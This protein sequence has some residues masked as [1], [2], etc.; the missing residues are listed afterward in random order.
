MPEQD[1][2]TTKENIKRVSLHLNA[3][4]EYLGEGYSVNLIVRNK[5]DPTGH[6][7][8]REDSNDV[9]IQTLNELEQTKTL[10]GTVDGDDVDLT[11][12]KR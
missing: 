9:I 6:V 7:S 8:V 1:L 5:N 4:G 2:E 3:I 12:V 11:P 10:N